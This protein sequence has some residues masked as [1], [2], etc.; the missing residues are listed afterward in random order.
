[1][2][3]HDVQNCSRNNPGMIAC[4]RAQSLANYL[5]HRN[6]E[7]VRQGC[8]VRITFPYCDIIKLCWDMSWAE[9]G[10][11]NIRIAQFRAQCLTETRYIGF[12]CSVDG[13]IRH[14]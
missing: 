10:D 9:Y 14:W 6:G 3:H 13:K 7:I 2:G 4:N 12:R 11:R 8:G 1:G 5:L